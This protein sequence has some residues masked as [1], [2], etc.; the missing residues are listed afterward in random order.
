MFT[1]T[2]WLLTFVSNEVAVSDQLRLFS[3]WMEDITNL[4]EDSNRIMS[5]SN[6]VVCMCGYLS[7]CMSVCMGMCM[8]GLLLILFLVAVFVLCCLPSS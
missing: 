6:V 1:L 3:A 7:V 2:F 8:G 5:G 4:V